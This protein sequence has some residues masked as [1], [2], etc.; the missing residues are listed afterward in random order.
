M[1]LLYYKQNAKTKTV[2]WVKQ[3]IQTQTEIRKHNCTYS[4]TVYKT[5]YQI[6]WFYFAFIF[7]TVLTLTI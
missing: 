1:R 4:N 5:I 6:L 7:N 3:D 2:T